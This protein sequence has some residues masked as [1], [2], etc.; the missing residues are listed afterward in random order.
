MSVALKVKTPKVVQKLTKKELAAQAKVA[1]S[2]GKPIKTK[3]GKK[4]KKAASRN[5]MAAALDAKVVKEF[6]IL[7]RTDRYNKRGEATTRPISIAKVVAKFLNELGIGGKTTV[8]AI[9]SHAEKHLG[10]VPTHVDKWLM[11][12]C[13]GKSNAIGGIAIVRPKI[14]MD[15]S[16]AV[17]VLRLHKSVG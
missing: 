17:K 12:Q 14:S 1:T 13:G 4:A 10:Y 6:G 11:Q 3:T 9:H 7:H 16:G 2:N 8:N 5:G 15:K